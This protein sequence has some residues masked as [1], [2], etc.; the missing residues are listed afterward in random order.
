M[1]ECRSHSIHSAALPISTWSGMRY[2]PHA[3]PVNPYVFRGIRWIHRLEY[4]HETARIR[5]FEPCA[6]DRKSR[7]SVVNCSYGWQKL[8]GSKRQPLPR[9]RQSG[10]LWSQEKEVVISMTINYPRTCIVFLTLINRRT[11]VCPLR[12]WVRQAIK[13]PYPCHEIL[14]VRSDSIPDPADP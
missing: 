6:V 12:T 13:L 1:L 10:I 14:I 9:S 2:L 4:L 3:S 11:L 8:R 7:R 5:I